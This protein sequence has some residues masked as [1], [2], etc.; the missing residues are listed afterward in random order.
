M[1]LENERT[2]EKKPHI[3]TKYKTAPRT[4]K[5]NCVLLKTGQVAYITNITSGN[6]TADFFVKFEPHFEVLFNSSLVGIFKVHAA[7]IQG[8]K[9]SLIDVKY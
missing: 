3:S 5:V 2:V 4:A 1:S 9:V 6:F 8:N 7:V